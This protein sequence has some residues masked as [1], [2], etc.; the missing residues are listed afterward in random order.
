M[1]HHKEGL[2][3]QRGMAHSR[4]AVNICSYLRQ[5]KKQGAGGIWKS[6]GSLGISWE[7]PFCLSGGGCL[8]EWAHSLP[9]QQNALPC[10][11]LGRQHLYLSLCYLQWKCEPVKSEGRV[12]P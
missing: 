8:G 3:G 9:R 1:P 4:G 12:S 7:R 10:A 2:W 5:K 6:V 11:G